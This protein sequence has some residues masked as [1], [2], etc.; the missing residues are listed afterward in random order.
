[1]ETDGN[2]VFASPALLRR[3]YLRDISSS[4][5]T[6]AEKIKAGKELKNLMLTKNSNGEYVPT[7]HIR[8]DGYSPSNVTDV[9]F[10]SPKYNVMGSHSKDFIQSQY[11]EYEKLKSKTP[12]ID[13]VREL[14]KKIQEKQREFDRIANY[15]TDYTDGIVGAY[16]WENY[17]PFKGD[18]NNKSGKFSYGL[19]GISGEYAQA[20]H[21]F[22]GKATEADNVILQTIMDAQRAAARAGR[23][24]VTKI[25][26]NLINLKNSDG[27]GID[28]KFTGKTITPQERY[29]N[30]ELDYSKI[31]GTDKFF[32]YLPNG[33]IQVWKIEDPRVLN[34]IRTSFEPLSPFWN[35]ASMATSGVGKMN[36]RYNLSFGP[37]NYVKHSLANAFNIS[38]LHGVGLGGE[39]LSD[40]AINSI[41]LKNVR[42]AY[43]LSKALSEGNVAT[44]DKMKT[45]RDPLQRLMIEYNQMGG[46]TVYSQT[47][48]AHK[49]LKEV[50]QAVG[51]SGILTKASHLNKILDAYQDI[52]DTLSRTTLYGA[53]KQ[54][55][56]QNGMPVEKAMELAAFR[57]KNVTNY[58]EIGE[59]GRKAGAVYMF[60]RPAA[61]SS[62]AA[63]DALRPLFME[64]EESVL[65][66]FSKEILNDPEKRKAIIDNYN[67]QRSNAKHL[68]LGLMGA[69]MVLYQISRMM[70]VQ[71]PEDRNMTA[72]DDKARWTRFARLPMLSGDGFFQIPWGFGLGGLGALGAQMAAVAHGDQGLQDAL[73][74]TATIFAESF[75]P[76]TPSH[77]PPNN[78]LNTG[79]FIVDTV[80]PSFLRPIQSLLWNTDDMGNEIYNTR[81]GKFSDSY[82]G[83]EYLPE[84]YKDASRMLFRISSKYYDKPIEVSPGTLYF[85]ANSYL[86]G[87]AKIASTM[88]DVNLAAQGEKSPDLR[89]D[90]LLPNSFMGSVSNVDARE[91]AKIKDDV[92]SKGEVL[93]TLKLADQKGYLDFIERHPN[94]AGIVNYFN[95]Q[96]A[97]Q[98][99]KIQE[100]RTQINLMDGLS[101]EERKNLTDNLRLHEN[102][103]KKALIDQFHSLGENP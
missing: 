53:V 2:K 38:S 44:I 17:V 55:L 91:W 4:S 7:A 12:E 78:L 95:H 70:N 43:S 37:I 32:H 81:Q 5:T 57:A 98:L 96:A 11:K 14:V 64:T 88:W 99:K 24:D 80:T 25:L 79:K 100:E 94:Y 29:E 40:L 97:G 68:T 3:Q 65:K 36:T 33:D 75:L 50:Q 18:G 39:Y 92:K 26:V 56:I 41:N 60:F 51:K 28:G 77:I 73:A 89:K 48:N 19:R 69:G 83:G 1:V 103:L 66:K 63:I 42:S 13:N 86:D 74:N 8:Q 82:S 62:A 52:F 59:W 54:N 90:F 22:D 20:A 49:Q 6:V 45:G 72:A 35:I 58:R 46:R 23:K 31:R 21:S 34:S 87:T 84:A 67:K 30:R 10:Y 85:W 16:G 61:A 101:R 102:I 76:I 47:Y 93:N 71:D 27:I 15:W 9:D